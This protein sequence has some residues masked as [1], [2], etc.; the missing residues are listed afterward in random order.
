MTKLTTAAAVSSSE[1]SVDDGS[2][3]IQISCRKS[4]K[5]VWEQLARDANLTLA[6]LV[7]L[8]M[9]RKTRKTIPRH[10]PALIRQ[11]S[12]IGNNLNQIAVMVRLGKMENS[13]QLLDI[14]TQIKQLMSEALEATN[15]APNQA[16]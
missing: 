12:A 15:H 7:R 14:I 13:S 1:I 9:G 2:T 6:D 4:E 5:R 11:L 8:Q 10:D 16:E 3:K